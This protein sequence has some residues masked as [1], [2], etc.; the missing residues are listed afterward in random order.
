[1]DQDKLW[2]TFQQTGKVHDYLRYC[3]IDVYRNENTVANAK[4]K[5]NETDD[6]RADHTRK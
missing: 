1:M 5:P 4:E 3:G 2:A 6:R